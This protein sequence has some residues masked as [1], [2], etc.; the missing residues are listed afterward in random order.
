MD[1]S[2]PSLNAMVSNDER[3]RLKVDRTIRT[4][5]PQGAMFSHPIPDLGH[6]PSPELNVPTNYPGVDA[7]SNL[8]KLRS[9]N[10]HPFANFGSDITNEM[11]QMK[12]Q[13]VVTFERQ[14]EVY[15]ERVQIVKA[16]Y[17]L[18]RGL[19]LPH[20]VTHISM[21][22][23]SSAWTNRVLGLIQLSGR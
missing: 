15:A 20:P 13:V 7:R 1:H 3:V 17:P 19:E 22:R 9:A 21:S 18:K 10:F 8:I 16:R 2:L 6:A 23:E 14:Q 5:D 4:S 11:S 12:G